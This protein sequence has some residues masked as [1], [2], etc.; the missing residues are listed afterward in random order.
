MEVNNWWV[1]L[2][3]ELRQ[4]VRLR[5]GISLVA[6]LL[7]SYGAVFLNNY[8]GQ[9]QQNY[10]DALQ[11]LQQLRTVATQ[12]QWVTRATQVRQLK[13]KLEARLWRA[14][15][16]GL[17]QA[18][19]QSWLQDEVYFAQFENPRL[20]MQTPLEVPKYPHLWQVT[21][22]LNASFVPKKLHQ[23]LS[24]LL[25]HPQLVVIETLEVHFTK[26]NLTVS[27]YFLQGGNSH[28]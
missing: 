10:H 6:A 24:V 3:L 7:L 20:E 14:D 19:F 25:Q 16:K 23:F 15:T 22:R 1:A 4:N 5:M 8:R 17:A 13:S 18:M 11:Q 26:V 9:W 2:N 27:A 12:S 21:A 28:D